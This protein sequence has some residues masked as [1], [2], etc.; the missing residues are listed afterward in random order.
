[1]GKPGVRDASGGLRE[2][3]R[4]KRN[5]GESGPTSAHRDG[6]V[7]FPRPGCEEGITE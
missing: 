5:Q 4:V 3:Y 2:N 1:M 6:Q 7:I